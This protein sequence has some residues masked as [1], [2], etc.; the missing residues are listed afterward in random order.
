MRLTLLLALA[1]T[2]CP[3]PAP[4]ASTEPAPVS[5]PDAPRAK[6][7]VL[8]V[9]D[10]LPLELLEAARPH[11]SGGFAR[12]TGE[13]AAQGVAV[14]PYA[15]TQT[16]PGHVTLSTGTAPAKSGIVANYWLAE[17]GFD[18]YCS[19][20]TFLKTEPV[21]D[22]VKAAGGKVAALSLKDRASVFLGGHDP[23]IVAW[24]DV[25]TDTI[26]N[27]PD[28]VSAERREAIW[29]E[30]WQVRD[31][32]AELR[33]DDRPFEGWLGL[34]AT[35]PHGPASELK[36]KD[37]IAM[38][39]AGVLL[40]DMAVAAVDQLEL[41]ADDQ[42]DLLTV[43]YSNTDYVGHYFTASSL[44]A[45]DSLVRVDAELGR[46]FEH[47]DATVG[48]GAWTVVLS[49]DHGGEDNPASYIEEEPL[50]ERVN[51]K[52]A[53]AGI[54]GRLEL[55]WPEAAVIGAAEGREA[56]A[57]TLAA[58]EIAAS[59]GVET[60]FTWDA[61]PE[62]SWSEAVR[63]SYDA[64]R[65]A[66]IY[67]I[68]AEGVVFDWYD[69]HGSDHGSP[70]SYDQRVPFLAVGAGVSPQAVGDVDSRQIAPTLAAL[71]GVS[72][73]ADAPLEAVPLK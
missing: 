14:F 11:F 24:Y 48:E 28:L 55:S 70:R 2:A 71:L 43:S 42:P 20:L 36:G 13:Q 33:E 40:T 3:K 6:L 57:N 7:V 5:V 54:G 9:I 53:E 52:L 39:A 62:E 72:P 29:S 61:M 18:T 68:S 45:L 8:V 31:D 47:L 46:L 22:Q 37:R 15:T 67:G 60:A 1:L 27:A 38:P 51:A 10:Q 41:G 49:S 21:A 58:A 26:V 34:D 56:E 65:S 63:L 25:K 73:P 50:I 44:E 19:D 12:L 64:E 35:F 69:G 4:V 23:D 17:D 16:C 30:T 66:P 59:D 32:L